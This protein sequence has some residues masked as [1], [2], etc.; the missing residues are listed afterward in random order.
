MGN[1]PVLNPNEVISI[2]QR[3]GFVEVRQ[4]GSHK[5]FRHPDG[6]GTTVPV[7]KAEIFHPCYFGRS[8]MTLIL[9]WKKCSNIG[10]TPPNKSFE[11]TARQRASHQSCV[12]RSRLS[13][14]GGQ[15]LNS[16]IRHLALISRRI[17]LRLEN[18]I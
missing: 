13:L 6:R 4:R 9:L 10:S 18:V 1:I 11:R 17:Y 5:Q 8:Q 7:H 2:L 12:V 14:A 3:L 15:P 16:G